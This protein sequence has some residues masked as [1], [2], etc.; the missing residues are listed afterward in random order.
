MCDPESFMEAE[1][2]EA[3]APAWAGARG[4]LEAAREDLAA[5]VEHRLSRQEG[6][7]EAAELE[8]DLRAR[9]ERRR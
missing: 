4:H 7:R 3:R 5:A 2:E 8:E 1:R 9:R 6:R